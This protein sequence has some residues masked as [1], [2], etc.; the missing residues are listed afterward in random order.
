MLIKVIYVL[1]FPYNIIMKVMY[2][3][4]IPHNIL[5][6]IHIFISILFLECI[7]IYITHSPLMYF[8]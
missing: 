6:K 7:Y 8:T 4:Y 5:L 1:D 3:L 2:A